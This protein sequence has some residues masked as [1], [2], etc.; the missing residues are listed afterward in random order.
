M[1]NLDAAATYQKR[2]VNLYA[3]QVA[4]YQKRVAKTAAA[5]E[6]DA[7]ADPKAGA[8]ANYYETCDSP[9]CYKYVSWGFYK[10][11]QKG[12]TSFVVGGRGVFCKECL[13]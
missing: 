5:A 1:A 9:N 12:K 13:R 11:T 6:A 3:A 10:K 7:A 8:P 2:L 4:A